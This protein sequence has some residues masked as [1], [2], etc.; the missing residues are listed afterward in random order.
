MADTQEVVHLQTVGLTAAKVAR[1]HA[2][3]LVLVMLE[4]MV[5]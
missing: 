4:T 3:D 1:T 5:K 2:A